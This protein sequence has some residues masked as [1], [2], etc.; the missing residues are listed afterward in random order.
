MKSAIETI[1]Y[2]DVDATN[3]PISKELRRVQEKAFKIYEVLYESF[4]EEQKKQYDE[5]WDYE[6]ERD[7]EISLQYFKKGFKIGF[8][9]AL[10]GLSD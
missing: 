7:A 5:M 9:L 1:F 3:I 4:T 10:D 2:D 8:K 6:S